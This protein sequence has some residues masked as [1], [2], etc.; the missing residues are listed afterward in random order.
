MVSAWPT[1]QLQPAG[2]AEWPNHELPG[3]L[4]VVEGVD[5]SGRGTQLDLL[6]AW[7][8]AEGYGVVRTAWNSSKLVSKTIADARKQQT[9]TPLTYSIL[10]A[11]DVAERQQAEII[12]AL[13]AGYVVLADRYVFTALA[14]DI[15][16]GVTRDWMYNL[17]SFALRPDLAIYLRVDAETSMR[18]TMGIAGEASAEEALESASVRGTVASF[19]VFQQRVIEEYDRLIAPFGLLPMDAAL[20]I[21]TQQLLL[22]RKVADML[23]SR[24]DA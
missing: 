17:Y 4:V 2:G 6:T 5:G 18:R 8:Q 20:P 24:E 19:R 23:D 7:L 3:S 15:A 12:P 9:L 11:T 16:R 13:E 1:F 10:H 14:R 21:R 22:R